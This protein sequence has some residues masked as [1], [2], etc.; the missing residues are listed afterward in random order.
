M[1]I[2]VRSALFSL[3]LGALLAVGCNKKEEEPV[4]VP[5]PS[6]ATSVKT[7]VEQA[8][9]QPAEPA[10]AASEAAAPAV[11]PAA[12]APSEAPKPVAQASIDGCCSALA[13]IQKSGLPANV[14]AKA[15]VAS[16]TCAGISKLVKEGKTSRASALA[17]IGAT[18]GGAAPSECK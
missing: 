2:L 3:A 15:A 5:L 4:P 17:Q 13:G 1:S 6:A 12:P 16:A 14:K 18:M 7:V 11:T 9:A 10:P 8:P